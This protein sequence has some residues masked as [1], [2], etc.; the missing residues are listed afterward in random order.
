MTDE[1]T[2]D[3][4]WEVAG[5]IWAAGKVDIPARRDDKRIH[6][7]SE[8]K[9][10]A[11]MFM[12]A[13]RV[14][15]ADQERKWSPDQVAH[16]C[17]QLSEILYQ[18]DDVVLA[19]MARISGGAIDSLVARTLDDLAMENAPMPRK[20]RKRKHDIDDLLVTRLAMS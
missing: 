2:E 13:K 5:A 7:L 20:V 11:G 15:V 9:Y 16:L 12:E 3:P 4:D 10:A 8:L 1:T 6:L 17:R 19:R 18:I 14:T